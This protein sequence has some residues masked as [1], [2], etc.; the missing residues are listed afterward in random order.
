MTLSM[1]QASVPAFQKHLHALDGLLDKAASYAAAKK[2]DAGVLLA[3]RLYP[4]MYELTRQVQA[5]TDFAKAA[6]TR[7]SGATVPSFADT[8]T[9]IPELKAR[10]AKTLALL[11]AIK[12]EQM[13]GSEDSV[14]TLKVGPNDMTFKG[15]DYLLHFALPNFYFHC[16]TAYAILRHNGVEIGKRDFMRRIA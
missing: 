10:I 1:Y 11:D 4:D 5:A 8:E 3:S 13:T 9:T 2:I 6:S 14:F 16:A 12:P 15:S 7:L